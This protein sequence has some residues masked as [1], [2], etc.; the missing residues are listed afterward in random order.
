MRFFRFL[1]TIDIINKNKNEHCF[2]GSVS[3]V[4]CA[5]V[6]TMKG[7]VTVYE[8]ESTYNVYSHSVINTFS[9]Y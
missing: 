7:T 3:V 8:I 4:L 1:D 2:L 9:N 6:K 5:W